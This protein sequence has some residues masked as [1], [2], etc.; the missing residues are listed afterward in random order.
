MPFSAS[1]YFNKFINVYYALHNTLTRDLFGA[2]EYGRRFIFMYD[3]RFDL[4]KSTIDCLYFLFVLLTCR[5]CVM[6]P[7]FQ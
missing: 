5:R 3:N 7:T 6:E 1:D 4:C 2:S